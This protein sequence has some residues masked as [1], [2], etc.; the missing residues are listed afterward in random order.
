MTWG[1]DVAPP[2]IGVTWPGRAL[3]LLRALV[4]GVV[5]IAGVLALVPVRMTERLALGLRRPVSPVIVQIVCRFA[6]AVLGLRLRVRGTP[7][8]GRGAIVAN[9]ASWLDILVLNA[10][11]RVFFVAK[12]EVAAWP[13]I[14]PLA[15][16]VGTVFIRRDR[17]Q[18]DLQ[19]LIFEAR[20]RAGH[21]LLFFPE[22]TSSDGTRVLPF[23]ST[24]F[25]AFFTP[26]LRPLLRIQPA[27]VTYRAPKGQDARLYGWWG[28]MEFGAH[29]V[30]ILCQ[31]QRGQVDVIFHPALPLSGS[32]DRKSLAL[33]CET[34][35]RAGHGAG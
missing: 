1:L 9:H 16:M 21:R 5:L 7:L 34:A 29:F 11:A 14:G 33:A 27:S 10:A 17:T 31:T 15:R 26:E 24:L 6:L 30:R 3:G 35:V 32:P 19:R 12:S 22:G 8:R 25:A 20:L 13:V 2:Q 18:A 28:S 23:K 4:L